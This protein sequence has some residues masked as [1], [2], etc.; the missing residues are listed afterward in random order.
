MS[1]TSRSLK[2]P[3]IPLLTILNTSLPFEAA[4]TLVCAD[5]AA[6]L[7]GSSVT[8]GTRGSG[9]VRGGVRFPSA[10]AAG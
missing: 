4:W 1:L 5:R 7:L 6:I 3:D 9:R 8:V 2:Q 10:G